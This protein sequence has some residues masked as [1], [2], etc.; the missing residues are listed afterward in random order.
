MR[1]GQTAR[2]GF[3]LLEIMIVAALIGLLAAIAVPNYVRAHTTSKMN[4]CINNL[5]LIDNAKQ[6]WAQDTKQGTNAAP[7]Y[8][9]ISGY[10]KSLVTCPAGGLNA[11]FASSY[12]IRVIGAQPECRI[13]PLTHVS[14]GG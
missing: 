7:Q 14:P 4:V 10:M 11:T 1:M 6:Q 3:T 2:A 5:R 8:S 9:D 13:V 12:N